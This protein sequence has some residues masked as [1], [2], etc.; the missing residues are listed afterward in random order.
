MKRKIYI[1][2]CMECGVTFESTTPE[3]ICHVCGMGDIAEEVEDEEDGET[4]S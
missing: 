4:K 3:E 2:T 1:Y